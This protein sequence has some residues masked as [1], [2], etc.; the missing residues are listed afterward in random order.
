MT[1]AA[2]GAPEWCVTGGISVD[3]DDLY[4]L[5]AACR[6]AAS[7]IDGVTA[8]VTAACLRGEA[9]VVL[10][11]ATASVGSPATPQAPPWP[12]RSPAGKSRSPAGT[13]VLGAVAQAPRLLPGVAAG[14]A[15]LGLRV[16][17]AADRYQGTESAVGAA[18][19]S[20][21]TTMGYLDRLAGR[22]APGPEPVGANGGA[23]A[24]DPDSWTEVLAGPLAAAYPPRVAQ[25][26][27]PQPLGA[28]AAPGGLG[29]LLRLLDG[30]LP[31]AGPTSG[32]GGGT[33][34]APAP[35]GRVDV[36]AVTARGADGRERT[37]YVVALPGTSDWSPPGRTDRDDV[38]NLHAN[39]QLMSGNTTAEL[40]ALPAA[41]AAAGVPPGAPVLLVGHSQGGM[42][43]YAA[44]SDPVLAGRYRLGHVLVAGA[45]IG[46]MRAPPPGVSVLALEHVGDVVPGLAARPNLDAATR[47]TIR[48][49]GGT[50]F[51]AHDVARYVASGERADRDADPRVA[52]YRDALRAAGFLP[53]G[54][55]ATAQLTRV[56]LR[57]RPPGEPA[58]GAGAPAR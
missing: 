40:A 48:C 49:D 44:A 27:P 45:P 32:P 37:A 31:D 42:T 55:G 18:V 54:D 35:P 25:V 9:A 43:A 20:A 41:L 23:P 4:A 13:A 33:P 1:A 57:L 10:L 8:R 17:L 12:P 58:A 29:D 15:A 3:V 53:A 6:L 19:R 11:L 5:A 38:R 7:G 36:L 16:A 56:E 24:A 51:A 14:L 34:G 26:G 46:A 50:G 30:A 22:K 47:V 2:A 52:A 21:G 39:L 28:R